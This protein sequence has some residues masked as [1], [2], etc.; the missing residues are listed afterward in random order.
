MK[1][2]TL[3]NRLVTNLSD[4]ETMKLVLIREQTGMAEAALIRLI[5]KQWLASEQ[6]KIFLSGTKV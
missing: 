5:I 2:T 4:E 6:A 3:R 1:N